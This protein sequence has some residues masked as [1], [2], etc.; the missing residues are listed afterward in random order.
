VV[1][2]AAA[3]RWRAA[4][5]GKVAFT[6]GV[7]DLLH[8]GHVDVLVAARK[9]GDWLIVGV[10]SDASARGLGKAH[11]I[12][13]VQRAEDRALM[14]ASLAC[15][16]RVVIFDEDTPLEVIKALKPKVLVKGGDYV[17]GTVVGADVIKAWNGVVKIVKLTPGYSTTS[18]I[19]S[20]REKPVLD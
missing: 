18:M 14:V 12:R 6:N 17:P 15:V 4:R 9:L 16:D 7:F 1:S 20:I 10:N 2:L 13:P 3:R 8:P 11:V 5:R 19:V